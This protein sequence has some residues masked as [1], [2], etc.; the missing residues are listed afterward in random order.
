[1]LYIEWGGLFMSKLRI[2][3]NE[4]VPV[5]E[6]DLGEKVVYGSELHKALLVKTDFSTWIKRR[7][8]ECDA[9]KKKLTM[10]CLPKLRSSLSE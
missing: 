9:Q 8:N 3:E 2:L 6:T 1:M 7:L 10:T 4:L 5:Y